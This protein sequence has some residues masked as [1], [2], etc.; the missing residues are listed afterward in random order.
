MTLRLLALVM[1]FTGAIGTEPL[2]SAATYFNE[3]FE[4]S[5]QPNWSTDS[6][7]FMGVSPPANGCN[8]FITSEIAHGGSKAL[9]ADYTGNPPSRA[10]CPNSPTIEGGVTAYRT[11]TPTVDHWKRFWYRTENFTYGSISTKNVYDYTT[12]NSPSFVWGHHFGDRALQLDA[13]GIP[14]Q[15]CPSGKIGSTCSFWPNMASVPLNDNQWYCIETHLNLGTAG[16]SDGS[17]EIFINGTQTTGY[18]NQRF[19]EAGQPDAINQVKIYAQSGSGIMY[20][21]DFAIGNSRIGCDGASG[22]DLVPPASPQ[23]L[24]LR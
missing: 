14:S 15:T 23:G 13:Q 24:S 6:C 19:L 21:D 22:I 7:N 8:P 5:L 17:I 4:G 16:G 20:Y 1:V 11:Y 18:Y 10:G 2:A 9:R 3:G 12:D